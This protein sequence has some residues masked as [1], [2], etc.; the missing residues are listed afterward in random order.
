MSAVKYT[1][2]W[3]NSSACQHLSDSYGELSDLYVDFLLIC[4]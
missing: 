2:N 1:V 4:V 3:W